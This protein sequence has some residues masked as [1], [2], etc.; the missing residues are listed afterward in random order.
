MV[1]IRTR[2]QKKANKKIKRIWKEKTK[3]RNINIV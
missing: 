2:D 3:I 1:N